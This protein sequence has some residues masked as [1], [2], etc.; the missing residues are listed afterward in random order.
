[1]GLRTTAFG[2]LGL[3]PD[4]IDLTG[5]F[6]P[7]NTSAPVAASNVGDRSGGIWSVARTGVGL[8]VVTFA[9]T[10]FSPLYSF[11]DMYAPALTANWVQVVGYNPTNVTVAG[12]PPASLKVQVVNNAGA[13]TEVGPTA[14]LMI[15]FC[16]GAAQTALGGR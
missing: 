5:M 13:A 2:A 3:Q 4:A 14:G 1:M 8:F 7:N 10:Y 9:D 12:I 11:A 15:V 6:A 16:C